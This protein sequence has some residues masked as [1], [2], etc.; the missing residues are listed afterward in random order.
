ML[1]TRRD[2][3]GGAF[4]AGS[5]GLCLGVGSGGNTLVILLDWIWLRGGWSGARLGGEGGERW[6]G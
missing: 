4:L 3:N 6:V 2:L 1:W 5:H